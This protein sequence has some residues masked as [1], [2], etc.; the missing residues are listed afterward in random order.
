MSQH[1]DYVKY[2]RSVR[3]GAPIGAVKRTMRQM[4]L[5]ADLLD[6][7][8]KLIALEEDGGGACRASQWQRR[9]L[10]RVVAS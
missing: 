2:F 6:T 3:V 4:G 8:D 9:W 5:D 1:P 7:P 10:V